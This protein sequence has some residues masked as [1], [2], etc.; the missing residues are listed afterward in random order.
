VSDQDGG[1]DRLFLLARVGFMVALQR[2]E[3]VALMVDKEDVLESV[4]YV[5]CSFFLQ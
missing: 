2:K 3:A 4:S 1:V 5:R